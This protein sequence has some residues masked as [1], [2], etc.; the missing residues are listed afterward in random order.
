MK[1]KKRT[2]KKVSSKR[3]A[4]IA[5][6]Y[7]EMNDAEVYNSI[8]DTR[9]ATNEMSPAWKAFCNVCRAGWASILSQTESGYF[10]KV[11]TAKLAKK[12]GAKK[13]HAGI[14]AGRKGKRK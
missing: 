2:S 5:G 11:D 14:V 7:L 3:L 8:W 1:P 13:Q 9:K 10:A 12:L 6:R 4:S